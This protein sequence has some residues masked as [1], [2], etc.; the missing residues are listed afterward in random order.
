MLKA[1]TLRCPKNKTTIHFTAPPQ[2]LQILAR[3]VEVVQTVEHVSWELQRNYRL[4][5]ALPVID[6]QTDEHV[7]AADV[8]MLPTPRSSSTTKPI[9]F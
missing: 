2:N 3:L 7:E 6:N 4:I 5:W 9:F 1:G 8:D